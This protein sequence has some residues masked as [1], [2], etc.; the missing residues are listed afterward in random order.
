MQS[1]KMKKINLSEFI[2]HF[3]TV[4]Q[5]YAYMQFDQSL[6]GQINQGPLAVKPF[7]DS[8]I[9]SA[10]RL[11]EI[12]ND[13]AM[14][15]SSR[16]LGHAVSVMR[17]CEKPV[18]ADAFVD[19]LGVMRSEL[20]ALKSDL[21]SLH[22]FVL[23]REEAAYVERS[24]DYFPPEIAAAFPNVDYDL[25]QALLCMGYGLHTS[26]V[27]HLMRAM[28]ISVSVLSEKLNT[29]L[30]NVPWGQVLTSMNKA[31]EAMPKGDAKDRW[32]EAAA[33]LAFVKDAWR[34]PTM[35]PKKSYDELEASLILQ[36]V[37]HF[38]LSLAKLT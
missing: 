14:L 24:V 32:S 31:I 13:T 11:I 17:Q 29:K 26:V 19:L 1:P 3:G 36:A 16:L 4:S 33:Q 23:S 27:L 8:V 28:E 18:G 21:V 5:H 7:P 2:S 15:T 37:K 38:M 12:C 6:H 10:E 9:R 20:D 35:H 34:N 30:E 25:N 22:S